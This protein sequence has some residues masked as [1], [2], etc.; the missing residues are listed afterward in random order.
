[1]GNPSMKIIAKG[2]AG[3]TT[4]AV[5][6]PAAVAT[7][8]QPAAIFDLDPWATAACYLLEKE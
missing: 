6:F 2:G 4:L 3:K 1:M 5:H 8:G 7:P